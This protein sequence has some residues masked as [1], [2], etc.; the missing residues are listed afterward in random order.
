MLGEDFSKGKKDFLVY[1]TVKN[2]AQVKTVTRILSDIYSGENNSKTA[3]IL[4]R[5]ELL[6]PMLNSIPSVVDDINVSMTIPLLDLP[7][8]ELS[9][10]ILNMYVNLRKK[11]FFYK[12]V[13]N[14]L[15]DPKLIT[16]MDAK[17][18]RLKDFL[19][20]ITEKNLIYVSV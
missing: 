15:L 1:E 14:V 18:S 10:M 5:S 3:V 12:D 2:V 17:S 7:F 16:V 9:L 13:Q 11:S 19:D 4:P 6:I 20:S 8:S